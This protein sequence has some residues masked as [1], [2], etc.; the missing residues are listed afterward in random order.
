MQPKAKISVESPSPAAVESATAGGW[1]RH[2][3]WFIAVVLTVITVA[4]YWPVTHH[5]FLVYDDDQYVTANALVQHGLAADTMKWALLNPVASNWHP[6]TMLSHLL[7]CQLYGLNAGKHHFT[8]VLFHAVNTVLVFL[9]LRRLTGALWRSAAVAALFAWHPLHVE[10]VAWIAE[11]KDVLSGFFGLLSLLAYARFILDRQGPSA[12]RPFYRS[13]HYWLAWGLLALGLL[14]KPMLVTWPALLLL[15]DYWPGHR[16]QP[17]RLRS[18]LVEKLP[19]AA[20]A[21][22]VCGLT[23][24]VQRATGAMHALAHISPA[25]GCENALISWC[26][27]IAKTFWPVDLSVFYPYP[28]TWSLGWVLL[29]GLFLG[30]VS[31]LCW[32]ARRRQPFLWVGWCW[33]MGTLVPVIG[34][35]Q[36]GAQAMADRY[37]YLPSIGL[38][39]ALVWGG[40]EWIRYS[41][42][43]IAAGA[44]VLILT[45]VLCIGVSHRQIAYWQNSATLFEHAL[46]VAPDNEV[47]RNN[48]GAGL[49]AEGQRDAAI[50]QFRAAIRL[51]PDCVEA[52]NNLGRMQFETGD[53]N[54]AVAAYQKAIALEPDFSS[55]H[56]NLAEALAGLGQTSEAITQ[57][58]TTIQLQPDAFKAHNDLAV[59]LANRGQTN[60]ADREFQFAL[61]LRPDYADA[62]FNYGCRLAQWG[63]L[64]AAINELR[65]AARLNPAD[66]EARDELGKLL[67]KSGRSDLAED[68]YVEALRVNTKD[69][70]A[71]YRLG[72][73]HAHAGHND[74]AIRFFQQAVR[75]HPDFVEA[76]HNLGSLLASQGRLPEAISQFRAAIQQR[77]DYRD[78]HFNLANSLLKSGQLDEAAA[79]YQTVIRLAPDFAPAHFYFGVDLNRKHQTADAMR[80]L[81]ESIR[82]RPED[83]LAHNLLGELLAGA[84]RGDEAVVEFQTALHYQPGLAEASNNL[85]RIQNNAGHPTPH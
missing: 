52:Y 48:L 60:E 66:A 4:L 24:I 51:K 41:R 7:D 20:L 18:L 38:F 34:V 69:A 71:W 23:F 78:A 39:L 53:T 81:E 1:T 8:S 63:D 73:L 54:G 80:Q 29:A 12:A 27:Y 44:A 47:V 83:A 32:Q 6:V 43:L 31:V 77:P 61:W 25:M 17:G 30:A 22:A 72:N 28:A 49:A 45:L 75:A 2:A 58:N 9:L 65:V 46:L 74:E 55:A 76:R 50:E 67:A 35:V 11:R 64:P 36:V 10:S 82:L 85:V 19:F 37:T 33:F 14:S 79:E 26:R 15:L 59:L 84:G 40:F 62:H 57:L 13:S 68:A 16:F 3:G 42:A 70:E 5:D 56:Y 21:L